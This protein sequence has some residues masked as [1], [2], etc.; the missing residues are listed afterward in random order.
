MNEGR[1]LWGVPNEDDDD[2]EWTRWEIRSD[3]SQQGGTGRVRLG[4]HVPESGGELGDWTRLGPI[5][6]PKSAI[7]N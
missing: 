5:M 6:V 7:D 1:G 2:I 3:R 4:D